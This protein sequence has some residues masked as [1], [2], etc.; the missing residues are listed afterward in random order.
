MSS[1]STKRDEILD[2]IAKVA[3]NGKPSLRPGEANRLLK[4][5]T[6]LAATKKRK[7]QLEQHLLGNRRLLELQR[8]LEQ[9]VSA[10]EARMG[11]A[12]EPAGQTGRPP[13][14]EDPRLDEST[15][16]GRIREGFLA[17]ILQMISSNILSGVFTVHANGSEIRLY[18]REGEVFH[19]DGPD[20]SGEGAFFAAMSV[21][22]GRFFFNETKVLPKERTISGKTQFL[23]LEALR[24]IDEFKAKA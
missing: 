10:I 24:Q 2:L 4:R 22:E 8:E 21:E 5:Q 6:H 7:E 1:I 11:H 18:V 14:R 19:G 16:S 20:L 15:I 17:D 13:K 12:L 9:R 3:P 23:I